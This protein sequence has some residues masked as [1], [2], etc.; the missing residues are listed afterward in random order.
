VDLQLDH[1]L[2]AK[3]S[4]SSQVARVLTEKWVSDQLYCPACDSNVLSP[5]P[6]GTRVVDF[7]CHTCHEGFQLKSQRRPFG[8]KVTDAAYEP[9]A[10][11]I[12][13]DAAPNFVFLRYQTDRWRVRDVFFVPRYF[14][15]PSIIERRRALGPKAR[16]AGWV[17]CNILLSRLPLDAR[18]QAVRGEI[19][20]SPDAVRTSWLRFAFLETKDA[21]SRGWTADVLACVRELHRESFALA[22]LYS[23]EGR[24]AIMHPMNR[25]VRPKLRQQ[26]QVLRD[27]GVL[28]FLGG[29]EYRILL[30]LNGDESPQPS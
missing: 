2:A 17:G 15:S 12:E 11:R 6:A 30:S 18:I 4:S 16:R 5:N 29:G 28:E 24:L 21:E 1:G 26:L 3:Y 23:F 20:I 8:A 14:L 22:D 9:M 13:H 27:H 19:P 7:Q 25:N 10:E